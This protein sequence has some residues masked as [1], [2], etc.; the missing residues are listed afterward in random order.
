MALRDFKVCINYW[1]TNDVVCYDFV[2]PKAFNIYIYIYKA[3]LF[4]CVTLPQ[5]YERNFHRVCIVLHSKNALLVSAV[6]Y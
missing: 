2:L 6:L 5:P 4:I 1:I 3:E